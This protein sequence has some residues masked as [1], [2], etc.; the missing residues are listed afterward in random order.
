MALYVFSGGQDSTVA[1]A[2]GVKRGDRCACALTIDYGQVNSSELDAAAGIVVCLSKQFGVPIQH[3]TL[4]MRRASRDIWRGRP[5]VR[6]GARVTAG[7]AFVPNRNAVFLSLAVAFAM[8]HKFDK[9]VFGTTAIDA[10]GNRDGSPRFIKAFVAAMNIG[11][12]PAMRVRVTFP[13]LRYSKG[14]VLDEAKRLKIRPL[15]IHGTISCHNGDKTDHAWGRGCGR[16]SACLWRKVGYREHCGEIK[17][18][19]R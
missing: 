2:Q 13:L 18:T 5:M 17:R 9:V 16:C 12:V 3:H 10:N 15:V 1:L 11:V 19:V 4:F 14:E 6:P 7:T 8:N